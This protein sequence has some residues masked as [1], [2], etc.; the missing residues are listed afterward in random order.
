[1][2]NTQIYNLVTYAYQLSFP[3][4]ELIRALQLPAGWNWYDIE[5]TVAGNP[6]DS[7][8]RLTFQSLLEDRFKL[9]VH[10]EMKIVASYDLVVARGGSKLK[11]AKRGADI[12]V[13]GRPI[14]ENLAT[15]G[16]AADGDHLL[17]KAASM[18]QLATALGRELHAP[19]ID[20]TSITGEFDFDVLFS[21]SESCFQGAKAPMRTL[22]V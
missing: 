2:H 12:S 7:E 1:M 18:E 3:N 9:K 5:A 21:R 4:D 17:G 13:G 15:T 14:P 11:A 19:V 6:T 20:W 16:P 10:R 22:R 8:L